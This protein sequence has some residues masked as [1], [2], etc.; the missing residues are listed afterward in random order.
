MQLQI[1]SQCPEGLSVWLCGWKPP[2]LGSLVSFLQSS[3][4]PWVQRRPL[5]KAQATVSKERLIFSPRARSGEMYHNFGACSVSPSCRLHTGVRLMECYC[6]QP[7]QC[8]AIAFPTQSHWEHT[9]N[10]YQFHKQENRTQKERRVFSQIQVSSFL[11]FLPSLLTRNSAA[12]PL[13]SLQRLWDQWAGG[14]GEGKGTT[15]HP[16]SR[17]FAVPRDHWEPG[18]ERPALHFESPAPEKHTHIQNHWLKLVLSLIFS[19]PSYFPS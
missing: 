8:Q 3:L 10:T 14:A 6:P 9:G 4:L 11:P 12:F 2:S 1:N 15:W 19:A 7:L 13:S 5:Q 18:L 16:G 17:G